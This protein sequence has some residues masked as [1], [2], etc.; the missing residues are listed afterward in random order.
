MPGRCA[1]FLL[2]FALATAPLALELC[3]V[4]CSARPSSHAVSMGDSCRHETQNDFFLRG[5]PRCGDH[6]GDVEPF[7]TAATRK[8]IPH[9]ALAGSGSASRVAAALLRTS[10]L[11]QFTRNP[12]SSDQ[13][14]S[15]P[16]RM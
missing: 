15:L 2:A 9:T 5:T 6:S 3:D 11:Q 13:K 8:L 7:G 10:A 16:L 12:Q 1:A 4:V 14:P